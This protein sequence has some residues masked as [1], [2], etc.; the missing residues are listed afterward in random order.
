MLELS[1]KEGDTNN[2]LE[3]SNK[4]GDAS[5]LLGLTIKTVMPVMYWS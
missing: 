3:L 2:V 1:N 4:D 5:N